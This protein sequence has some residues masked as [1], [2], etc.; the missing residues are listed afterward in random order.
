M[1]MISTAS[2]KTIIVDLDRT[3][4]HTDKTLSAHTVKVLK[5]CKK[6][7]INIMVATARPFRATKQYC[8]LIGFDAMVVSNGARIIYKNQRTD[9]GICQRSA[10]H[11]LNALKRNPNLR[12]T[13]ETG[14]CAYSNHPIEDYETILTDNLVGIANKEGALKILVHLDS[15]ETLPFVQKELT[16]DLYYTIAHGYLLQIM[17]ASATKWNG[18]KAM[19][20]ICN[21]SPNETAYFGDDQDD[22]EPIKMCGLG[23][24][25]SNAID[26]VK[27]AADYVIE[28]NDADGVAKFIEHRILKNI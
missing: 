22:V 19:L 14:D 12:I 23:I 16:E 20:D 8:D 1:V 24:A 6:F 21:C 5:K 11:L 7:G 15:K 28:S 4:L 2:V 25:V 10:E 3:L 27:A 13:L 26:E 18:I 17:N 9:Y